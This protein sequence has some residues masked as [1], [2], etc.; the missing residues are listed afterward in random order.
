MFE[1]G[2]VFLRSAPIVFSKSKA[3]ILHLPRVRPMSYNET[4]ESTCIGFG[5]WALILFYRKQILYLYCRST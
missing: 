2:V 5:S 1:N 3:A 4:F